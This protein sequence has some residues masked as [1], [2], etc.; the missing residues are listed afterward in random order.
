MWMFL[1][2]SRKNLQSALNEFSTAKGK[3]KSSWTNET[4]KEKLEVV[5]ER[6]GAGV[7]GFLSYAFFNIYRDVSEIIHGSYYGLRIFLGMQNKDITAFKS[8]DEAAEYFTTHQNKL[9]T[10]IIQQINI[11]IYSIIEILHKEFNSL[12]IL[13]DLKNQSKRELDIYADKVKV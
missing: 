12:S 7:N 4:T 6:Y 1:N 9:A 2:S 8:S 5:G 11:S 13:E 3:E 10:L